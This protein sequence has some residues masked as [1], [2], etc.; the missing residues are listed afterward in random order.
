MLQPARLFRMLNEFVL[1]LLGA[2][3]ILLVI[4]G[5]FS[6][7][8]RPGLWIALGIFLIYW[9]ARAW[10]RPEPAATPRQ[11][12]VR[13]GSLALVG[14]LMLAIPLLPFRH[15]AILLGLA[16]VVLGIRG[17]LSGIHFA[18]LPGKRQL[19]HHE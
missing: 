18:R 13:G 4:S 2:L 7:P 10:I 8:T 3:L 19:G 5:R 6:I 14:L 1:F 9:G 17:I 16:G 15:A 11:K 12:A